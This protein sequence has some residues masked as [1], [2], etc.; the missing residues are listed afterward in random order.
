MLIDM[1]IECVWFIFR[2]L[3]KYVTRIWLII[4]T[5]IYENITFYVT[6]A[7]F[8]LSRL[9]HKYRSKVNVAIDKVYIK[10]KNCHR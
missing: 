4:E 3:E 9:R 8:D 10:K 5:F 7:I 6:L 2:K 1:L